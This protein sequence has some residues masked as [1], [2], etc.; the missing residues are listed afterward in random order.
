VRKIMASSK[1]YAKCQRML[2]ELGAPVSGWECSTV[3]DNETASFTCELCGCKG[4]RYIH[5]MKHPEY[6]DELSVGCICAGVMEGDILE[7]EKRAREAKNKSKR[8]SYY[9]KK[10]WVAVSE[11]QWKLTY[12]KLPLVIERRIFCGH[13]YYILEIDGDGFHWKDNRRMTSFLTAQHYT[14]NLIGEH[15]A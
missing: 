4:V 6:L 5:V 7:A 13:E 10:Q 14:F 15:Y 12:K 11:N 9:L 1:Y 3:S 8:K 2:E